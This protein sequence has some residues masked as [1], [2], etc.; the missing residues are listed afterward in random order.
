M[1]TRR[2]LA[3]MIACL[4]AGGC[5]KAMQDMYDQPRYKPFGAGPLFPDGASARTPP[6]GIAVHSLGP[7]AGTSSGRAGAGLAARDAELRAATA[8]PYPIGAALLRRGQQRFRIYCEPCHSPVGDGDGL[9]V[10]RG[11]PA[12][13]SYHIERLRRAPDRHFFE[14]ISRGH[15]IMFR[16][17]DRIPPADRWAIVAYIR[18]LQLSQRARLDDLPAALRDRLA[19]A[20]GP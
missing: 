11:F 20:E 1:S 19:A 10:R 5:E 15:G 18:A 2:L 8:Q 3:V 9:V 12:P 6:E 14:V 7:F 13:P 17:G 4:A 16:Y